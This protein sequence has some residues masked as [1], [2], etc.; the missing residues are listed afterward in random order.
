MAEEAEAAEAE[1]AEAEAAELARKPSAAG[2]IA[3][4]PPGDAERAAA[5]AGAAV[6]S[7]AAAAAST[8]L[9]PATR[10]LDDAEADSG[11]SSDG[12]GSDSQWALPSDSP[13]L[14]VP[15][16]A[17]RR[18]SSTVQSLALPPPPPPIQPTPTFES[19]PGPP[20]A[21]FVFAPGAPAREA[22]PPETPAGG[23]STRGRSFTL[24][25][26][27]AGPGKP[28]PYYKEQSLVTKM[29]RLPKV[30]ESGGGGSAMKAPATSSK[31]SGGSRPRRFSL[32]SE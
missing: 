2:V 20:A 4:E 30:G 11:Y 28:R 17:A 9:A 26:A 32:G 3:I 1:A 15:P 25:A 22:A 5:W 7:P 10:P 16:R 14:P 31:A 24:S 19:A 23:R 6:E 12:Y 29:R 13:D 21:A 8:P 27:S 18:N